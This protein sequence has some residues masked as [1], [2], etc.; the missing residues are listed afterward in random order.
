MAFG[1]EHIIELVWTQ[2]F[3]ELLDM[4]A[5]KYVHAICNVLMVTAMT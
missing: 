2:S 1:P 3:E 5:T 4:T